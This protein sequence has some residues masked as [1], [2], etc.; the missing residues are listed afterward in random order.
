MSDAGDVENAVDAAVATEIEELIDDS[1]EL[2]DLTA[3][4]PILIDK[5]EEPRLSIRTGH[6]RHIS[7]IDC[8]EPAKPGLDFALR[9]KLVADLGGEFGDLILGVVQYQGTG[10]TSSGYYYSHGLLSRRSSCR[11]QSS[12]CP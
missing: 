3:G 10:R 1:F 11:H 9:T 4:L 8:F 2:A 7:D 5:G 12:R 6:C